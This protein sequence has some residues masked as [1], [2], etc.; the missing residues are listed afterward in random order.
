[1][2]RKSSKKII[3]ILFPYFI[4]IIILPLILSKKNLPKYNREFNYLLIV[5]LAGCLMW[6]LKVPVFRYGYSYLIILF[7]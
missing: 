6:F 5:T 7:H 4:L 3:T 1:M 2:V